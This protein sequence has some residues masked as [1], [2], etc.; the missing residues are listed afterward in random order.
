MAPLLDHLVSI[1]GR[2][3]GEGRTT[4][5]FAFEGDFEIASKVR[6]SLIEIS[7]RAADRDSSFHEES[8]WIAT[9]LLTSRPA[10]WTVSTN[11]PGVLR[12]DLVEDSI[13][14]D[15]GARKIVFRLGDFADTRRFRQEISLEIASD[16]TL[17]YQY[18]WGVPH[19]EMK[20]RVRANLKPLR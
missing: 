12:H 13:L 14:D 10:L 7:F 5:G 9:D 1:S 20:P 11:T 4:D 2:Y 18:A 16:G 6:D 3:S 17:T 15:T 19:E 8:S